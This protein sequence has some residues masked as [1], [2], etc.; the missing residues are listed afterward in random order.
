MCMLLLQ[1]HVMCRYNTHTYYRKTCTE[2]QPDV[3]PMDQ[4]L[5]APDFFFCSFFM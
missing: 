5:V 4:A 2:K 1:E 3:Q